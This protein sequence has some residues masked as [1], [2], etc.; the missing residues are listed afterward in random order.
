MRIVIKNKKLTLCPSKE[1]EDIQ[2][3]YE[4]Q[5]TRGVSFDAKKYAY[6][7]WEV[8]ERKGNITELLQCVCD[9][10]KYK[11][12]TEQDILDFIEKQDDYKIEPNKIYYDSRAI[13]G[14]NEDTASFSPISHDT[15]NPQQIPRRNRD[16]PSWIE[17]HT[18]EKNDV[19]FHICFRNNISKSLGT[20]PY[21]AKNKNEPFELNTNN[22]YMILKA[23]RVFAGLGKYKER[24]QNK[25]KICLDLIKIV[26]TFGLTPNECEYN[27][28]NSLGDSK[29]YSIYPKDK[30]NDK[31]II[32]EFPKDL[33]IFNE[34]T[35]SFKHCIFMFEEVEE[36]KHG[37]PFKATDDGRMAE[38]II[39]NTVKNI[40][41]NPITFDTC[42]F[43]VSFSIQA[44]FNKKISFKNSI[45]ECTAYFMNSNFKGGVDF[46]GAIFKAYA[47]FFGSHFGNINATTKASQNQ[48]SFLNT[49]F[50][51]GID[52]CNS[53]F[54]QKTSFS[55]AIFDDFTDFNKAEFVAQV[56]FL[57]AKFKGAVSFKENTFKQHA[58]FR[59]AI[60]YNNVIFSNAKFQTEKN[61]RGS[62]NFSGAHF[63]KRVNLSSTFGRQ[64]NFI[65][66]I[67]DENAKFE[68]AEFFNKAMFEKVQFKKDVFFSKSIFKQD[69]YFK[70]II[71]YGNANFNNA[72]FQTEKVSQG[73]ADFSDSRFKERVFFIK[74]HFHKKANFSNVI[75][76]HNAYFDGARFQNEAIFKQSEFYANVHFYQT[77]FKNNREKFEREEPNFKQAIFNGYINLTDT[78]IFDFNFEQLKSEAQ[79]SSDA[80]GFRNIF[81]NI[82]NALIKDSNLIDASHFHKMELYAKELEI[83]YKQEKSAKDW[84]EQIQLYCYRLTSDHHTNLLLILNHIIFL[85]A[86]FY[87]A[88]LGL[89]LCA[90]DSNFENIIKISN[91]K[92]KEICIVSLFVGLEICFIFNC[93]NKI[94]LRIICI[95]ILIICVCFFLYFVYFLN[96]ECCFTILHCV[97]LLLLV[98][99]CIL[100]CLNRNYAFLCPYPIVLV[101]LFSNPSS[102]LPI[103]GK[104]IENKSAETCFLVIGKVKI[105]C[106]SGASFAPE[107][108]NLIYMLFL[109]LLL[110]SLQKTARKNTIVPS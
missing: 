62:A 11:F 100:R 30:D 17:V 53:D 13:D 54:K 56:D 73:I 44:D 2:T 74:S 83:S 103:L 88:N 46:S 76:D 86:L 45:F 20:S 75:F 61:S 95:C 60:F 50:E 109:F 34:Y 98:C 66:A 93:F 110:W 4:P 16:I 92:I 101:M 41:E 6:A 78:K 35:L 71:F 42:T 22:K 1:K 25:L 63:Q 29:N 27:I 72:K 96:V 32:N 24:I 28:D 94:I 7:D 79:T 8:S 70:N 105:L 43:R 10:C 68:G 80:K 55:N 14:T 12:Y 36:K 48:N 82:K 102:I 37:L 40:V 104:L 106:W 39:K 57:K 108:L 21:L 19:S 89:T 64:A 51:K 84:I 52:F 49:V 59:D 91:I 26:E 99:T 15:V 31:V 97:A 58:S 67:F 3:K 85:I 9:C 69:A 87:V 18:S 33:R 5:E 47:R 65:A 81:K 107:T 38:N 77:K 23:C 90:T